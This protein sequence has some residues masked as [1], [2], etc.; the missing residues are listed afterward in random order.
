MGVTICAR[1]SRICFDMGY[2]GFFNLRK[3]IAFCMNKD[4]GNLYSQLMTAR[5]ERESD[6]LTKEIEYFINHKTNWEK[7]Y[8]DVLDFLFESDCGG[9]A[10][11]KTCGKLYE[12]IKDVDFGKKCFQYAVRFQK[13]PVNDYE[14]L[15]VFLKEC[16][17]Y[18]RTMYWS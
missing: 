13:Q 11:Y 2:G 3:N 17:R 4:F 5:D 18:H 10:G 6:K 12:I 14:L 7:E 1:N 8:S 16:Y 15:K 9:K